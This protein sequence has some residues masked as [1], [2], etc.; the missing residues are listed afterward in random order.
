M[1]YRKEPV[2]N[3]E[4]Y[5]V[6]TNGVVY[7]KN[8]KP[9]KYSIN[10]SGYCIVNFYVNG[11][12]TGY[13]IHTLVA[14]QFISNN[15]IEATQ[16]NHKN[17]IKADNNADNLEWVTPKENIHHAK[18]ILH[19]GLINKNR[20]SVIQY[21]MDNNIIQTYNSLGEAAKAISEYYNLNYSY[22]KTIIWRVLKGI[23]KTYKKYKWKYANAAM[24]E[25]A[26]TSDFFIDI[27]S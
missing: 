3:F 7:A 20:K 12:R 4:M 5:Q 10:H 27:D 18:T 25:L 8:G 13:A 17:G 2:K 1:Q 23:R 15:N 19:K 24:V 22:T 11:K 26:D 14:K 9:L 6:D 16:V 21:D